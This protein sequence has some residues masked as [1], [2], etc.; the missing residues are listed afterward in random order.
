MSAVETP[1]RYRT[2]FRSFHSHAIAIDDFVRA[3]LGARGTIRSTPLARTPDFAR[4]RS[5]RS[6]D[7]AE[8]G[9]LRL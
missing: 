2:R 4:A 1:L 9:L 5:I 6:I 8:R 7:L 3:L